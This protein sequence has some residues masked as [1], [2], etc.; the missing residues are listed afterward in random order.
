MALIYRQTGNLRAVPILFG[1]TK[2]DCAVRYLGVDIK[3]ALSLVEGT[4]F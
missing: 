1:H 2:L 3:D 4:D